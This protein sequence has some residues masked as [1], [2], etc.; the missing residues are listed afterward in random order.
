MR[1]LNRPPTF[2]T[3]SRSGRGPRNV[4]RSGA[5]AAARSSPS[6]SDVGEGSSVGTG[7]S[8][9][10]AGPAPEMTGAED[11]EPGTAERCAAEG[12]SKGGGTF[13]SAWRVG[14]NGSLLGGSGSKPPQARPQLH[15][16]FFSAGARRPKVGIL[17]SLLCEAA[18]YSCAK[19]PANGRGRVHQAMWPCLVPCAAKSD[20]LDGVALPCLEHATFLA[21]APTH[22][23][24]SWNIRRPQRTAHHPQ[25]KGSHKTPSR[26]RP[27]HSCQPPALPETFKDS[28]SDRILIAGPSPK[29]PPTGRESLR[30]HASNS[31]FEHWL[32]PSCAQG[33]NAPTSTA[34]PI[35]YSMS[36]MMCDL[37]SPCEASS[38]CS[39]SI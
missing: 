10:V 14:H 28:P 23:L 27:P 39:I 19:K 36:G 30:A 5:A 2:W 7:N 1:R 9:G 4:T 12:G 22:N 32:K 31:M 16:M 20:S 33:W 26:A 18:R 38:R 15:A 3:L 25:H 35:C 21:R 37:V 17:T 29:R 13:S 6:A 34:N 24:Q 8:V 11:K